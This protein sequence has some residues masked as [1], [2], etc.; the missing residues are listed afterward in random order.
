MGSRR[1]G[2]TPLDI[3]VW[4]SAFEATLRKPGYLPYDL[5]ANLGNATN[6]S[7]GAVL[8]RTIRIRVTT[9]P[10]GVPV[11]VN[12]ELKGGS[13]LDIMHAGTNGEP[14]KV[15][16]YLPGYLAQTRDFVISDVT[17]QQFEIDM[18]EFDMRPR[19]ILFETAPTAGAAVLINGQQV[20]VTPFVLQAQGRTNGVVTIQR[21][22]PDGK[23]FTTNVSF[24]AS[25][26]TN[27]VYRVA[28]D[29]EA[30]VV[31]IKNSPTEQVDVSINGIHA[32]QTPLTLR[33]YGPTNIQAIASSM[34]KT[35]TKFIAL[36]QAGTVTW[37][38]NLDSEPRYVKVRSILK[39]QKFVLNVSM[40]RLSCKTVVPGKSMGRIKRSG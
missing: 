17:N 40:A 23:S 34:G 36:H 6:A 9:S 7:L 39:T 38:A 30:R 11:T 2:V 27:L 31:H 12:G 29:Q 4:S 28:L 13:P 32:G 21:T 35:N 1:V 24:D 37:Q 25:D 20:G 15:Q 33:W 16:A 22:A 19:R 14:V 26:S 5:F 8:L 3:A 18:G 10:V